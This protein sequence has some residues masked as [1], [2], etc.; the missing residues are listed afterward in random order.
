MD[1]SF[2]SVNGSAD[3]MTDSDMNKN[4]LIFMIY[5]VIY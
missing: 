2:S 5:L 1:R 3:K 4:S